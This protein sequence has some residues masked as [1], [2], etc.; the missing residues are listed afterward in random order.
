MVADDPLAG[1]PPLGR[2]PKVLL[3]WPGFPGSFW[4]FQKMLGMTSHRAV[5]PPL[6]LVTVAALCPPGWRLRLLD[7]AF[8]AVRDADLTWADLV[9]VSA[10]HVQKERVREVL[11]RARALG[12]RTL[13]GGPYASS[14]P[15]VLLEL[16]D[17]VVVGE[18]DEAFAG[19][20]AALEDGSARRLYT[21]TAKPD[22][23]RAPVPRFDLLDLRRY[24]S[25]AVQFSRGC[26][27]ECEFCDIITLYGRLPRTK[28]PRQLLAELDALYRLG[29]RGEVFLVDDNFIG[30][31]RRALELAREIAAWQ[32]ARGFPFIFYT[33]ASIDLAQRPE[34]VDAMVA[35]NFSF[36]FVGIESPSPEALVET[37]KYQNL[38]E[39]LLRSLRFLLSRGLW[40][41]GGFIV[42]FDSDRENIF[43]QQVRFIDEAAVP[44]AMI[45]LLQAPPTTPLFDR[46]LRDG[47]LDVGT[48]ATTNFSLPNF[49]TKM[50]LLTLLSGYRD[51]LARLYEPW[52]FYDRGFRSL[53][54]WKPRHGLDRMLPV[55]RKAAIVARSAWRQGVL[56]PYRAAYWHFLVRLL[57]FWLRN[58]AKLWL[59]YTVLLS[60]HHFIGYSRE[61]I[62]DL[63]R[64][65]QRLKREDAAAPSA[66]AAHS[67]M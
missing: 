63:D 6:G 14:Q 3:V 36:V 55:W 59:G 52:A 16:A 11:L 61:V 35:A 18:P 56:A 26:P 5:M 37:K 40:V 50:P 31:R 33:E 41:T 8:A 64:E 1:L 15:D 57:R 25:M 34:L 19:I 20:A 27:F 67:L 10:M 62:A 42:G 23:T 9:L 44:W 45:G 53:W 38:R 28:E 13:V 54:H 22:V 2:T 60:G 4:S 65:I 12:R 29:W 7:E 47:R 43:E 51:A 66:L 24:S 32:Q 46:M 48:Q 30:N 17:H 21:V 49:R 39:D 58:P